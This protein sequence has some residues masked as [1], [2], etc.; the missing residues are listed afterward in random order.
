MHRKLVGIQN[1]F[2]FVIY[3]YLS[4]ANLSCKYLVFHVYKCMLLQIG[5]CMYLIFR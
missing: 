2:A 3:S 1:K 4:T 5:R